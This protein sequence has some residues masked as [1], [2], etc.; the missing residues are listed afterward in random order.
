MKYEIEVENIKC[1]GCV[2]SI[3]TGLKELDGVQDVSIDI[4]LGLITVNS[5]AA[6]EPILGKLTSMG[7]PE[8]G[9]NTIVN[10]AKSFVSCA[11]GKF[12]D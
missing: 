12:N 7:Y 2:N 11:I 4:S 1:S 3:T 10:K 8:K 5:N 9:N 6:V